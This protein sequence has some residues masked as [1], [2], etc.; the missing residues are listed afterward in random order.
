V[1]NFVD[2]FSKPDCDEKISSEK[3]GFGFVVFLVYS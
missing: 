1:L 2:I 3:T